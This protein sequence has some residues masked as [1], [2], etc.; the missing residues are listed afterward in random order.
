MVQADLSTQ[1]F[2]K[3]FADLSGD[4]VLAEWRFNKYPYCYDQ[5]QQREEEP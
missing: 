1:V 2:G 5:E 4:P 3:P